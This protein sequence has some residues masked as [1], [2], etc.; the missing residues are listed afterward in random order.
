MLV[1]TG[2]AP[3]LGRADATRQ[4]IEIDTC[5]N[6]HLSMPYWRWN[7]LHSNVL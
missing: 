2:A 3:A 1:L 6:D 4:L 5:S 7:E